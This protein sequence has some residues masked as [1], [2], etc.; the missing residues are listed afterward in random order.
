[1]IGISRV[2]GV[3]E[4]D[5]LQRLKSVSQDDNFFIRSTYA[6]WFSGVSYR[7]IAEI[8]AIMYS[9]LYI[10]DKLKVIPVINTSVRSSPQ[11]DAVGDRMKKG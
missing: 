11:N 4:T 1:L 7:K 6:E 3:F 8:K 9:V 10:R 2:D 5:G